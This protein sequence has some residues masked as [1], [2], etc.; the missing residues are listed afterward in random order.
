M[1]VLG[2]ICGAALACISPWAARGEQPFP[3]LAHVGD[4]FAFVINADPHVSREKPGGRPHPHNQ[5]LRKFV[6]DV[7]AMPVPPAFVIF[8]GDIY[9]RSA[10]PQTTD[11]LLDILKGLRPLAIAVTGNH[12]VRDFDVDRIFRPVQ[13]A[14]NGTTADTFSFDVGRWHFVVM[15][16]RELLNTSEKEQAFLDWLDKDLKANRDRPTMA[17]THYHVL[18]VGV[19]QLEFYTYPIAYKNRLLDTLA[20]YGNVRWVFSGHVHAGIQAS[21]KTAWR[22][23]GIHF[24]IAPSPVRPR[25]F[26]EEFDGFTPDG[27]YY[28]VVDVQGTSVRLTG[29]Q[30]GSRAEHVYPPSFRDFGPATDPRSLA[31]VWDLPTNTRLENGGFENQLVGWHAPLRY[32]AD[33]DPGYTWQSSADKRAS[34]SH[35]ARLYVREK[36]RGWALGEFTELYQTVRVSPDAAPTLTLSYLPEA[37]TTGGGYIWLAGFER[38][39]AR[40]LMLFHWGPKLA[41]KHTLPRAIDYL[42]T[43]GAPLVPGTAQLQRN[44][45]ALFWS[46]PE[47]P[48]RWHHLEVNLAEAMDRA[49]GRKDVF[50]SLR[51]DRMFVAIGAWCSDEPGANSTAWFD[52]IAVE[53][54]ARPAAMTIDGRP[55]DVPP[56]SL[57]RIMQS[58]TE[59]ERRPETRPRKRPA[60]RG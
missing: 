10:A 6:R 32:R 8:N 27:G 2:S 60:A 55:F 22:Y 34:G 46:V 12:D 38:S 33:R 28:V 52:D 45:R 47:A 1:R 36:G 53:F 4:G 3:Q 39:E 40:C 35:A 13:K 5:L 50:A 31:A 48:D 15:P 17:F 41:S 54:N 16:T 51:I 23:R 20:R 21:I 57:D 44:G 26:G 9:E 49:T 37:T 29:R 56:G 14:L 25:P 24:I 19:S 30:I 7:N 11:T 59:S 58:E 42:L 43:A 18:P